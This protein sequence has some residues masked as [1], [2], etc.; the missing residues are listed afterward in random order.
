MS[1]TAHT[2]DWG[3]A[4]GGLAAQVQCIGIQPTRVSV[5][6]SLVRAGTGRIVDGMEY[7]V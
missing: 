1:I 7:W 5:L 6:R 2:Q 3:S 4:T